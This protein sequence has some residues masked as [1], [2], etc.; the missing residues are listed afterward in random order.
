MKEKSTVGIIGYGLLGREIAKHLRSKNY[1]VFIFDVNP[2]EQKDFYE[3]NICSES[4]VANAIQTLAKE[5][6]QLNAIV[7]C[8]Y[9]R[10]ANYGKKLEDVSFD[11]FNEN[12]SLHLGGYFNVMKQFGFYLQKLGGGNII[13]FSSIYGICSPRF[14]IYEGLHLTMPVEYAAIK[15]ALLHL[16]KYMAKY[17]KGTN[18]RFNSI[19]PGGIFNGHNDRFVKAYGEYSLNAEKG[20][21]QAHDLVASVELLVSEGGQHINGQN[22]IVDDGW[23]L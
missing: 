9:P 10:G 13:S 6:I 8:S 22:I 12:V 2:I 20:M 18:V 15:A 11:S 7:N 23:S 19:S 4:S 17:F 5:N 21:L 14:E 16:N 1:Q 3:M